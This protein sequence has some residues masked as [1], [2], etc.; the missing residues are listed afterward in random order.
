MGYVDVHTAHA[1]KTHLQEADYEPAV[2]DVVTGANGAVPDQFLRRVE[3]VLQVFHVLDIGR[4]VACVGVSW[5]FYKS[6]RVSANINMWRASGFCFG[7]FVVVYVLYY[8]I[9]C[10]R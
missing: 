7:P 4:F 5:K 8:K 9:M 10:T 3:R 6:A 2:A 1:R